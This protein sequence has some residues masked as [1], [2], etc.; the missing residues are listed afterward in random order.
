MVREGAPCVANDVYLLGANLHRVLTGAPR[1]GGKSV[2][3]VLDRALKSLPY[4]YEDDVPPELADLC[5]RSTHHDPRQ[6]P[7]SAMAFREALEEWKLHR[8]SRRLAEVG[9]ERLRQLQTELLKEEPDER[10][11]RTFASE[12]RFGLRQALEAWEDNSRARDSL[13]RC[14]QL[15]IP[16]SLKTGHA[17]EAVELLDE[18]EVLGISDPGLRVSVEHAVRRQRALA[19]LGRE[20]D[21][22]V[23]GGWRVVFLLAFALIGGVSGATLVVSVRG[24]LVPYNHLLSV[25]VPMFAVGLTGVGLLIARRVLLRNVASRRVMY[26]VWVVCWGVLLHRV[27]AASIGADIDTTMVG[28]LVLMAC[29]AGV[30]AV[31]VARRIFFL[32]GLFIVLAVI[33]AVHPSWAL[34][35]FGIAVA[36]A[37]A[38]LAV[39]FLPWMRKP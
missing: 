12:A 1:H 5:N 32:S 38:V 11:V 17:E 35:L 13:V 19:K 22:S 21:M 34:E 2:M 27:V 8:S 7:P 4:P 33:G 23:S 16:Q 10:Q 26:S 9:R 20:L 14:L 31:G 15:M 37:G 30:A 28:D 36:M 25:L 3:Q 6:R 29:G 24:G 39:L 18:L